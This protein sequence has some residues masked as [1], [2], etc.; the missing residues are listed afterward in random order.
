MIMDKR[1]HAMLHPDDFDVLFRRQGWLS[2]GYA[3]PEEPDPQLLSQR[4]VDSPTKSYSPFALFDRFGQNT[5]RKIL[6]YIY[7]HA[8]CT[9]DNL[10]L[11]CSNELLLAEHLDFMND[12]ELVECETDLWRKSRRCQHIDNIGRTLEWYVA[13]W[14]RMVLHAPAR[15]G[16]HV[17]NLADGGDL[18]VVAFVDGLRISVECKSG[19]DIPERQLGLFAQRA[20]EFSPDIAVLLIDTEADIEKH[21][22]V[23]NSTCQA[24]NPFRQQDRAGSL[25][26]GLR[27]GY[28]VNTKES[29]GDSIAAV[30][31]L[32]HSRVKHVPFVGS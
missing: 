4:W 9:R 25:Y 29:I 18:D 2:F 8:P 22:R 16:V 24:G 15:Y 17:D 10:A 12:Q 7:T 21:I 32:Y 1:V 14:F 30:L 6:G 13:E 31:R 11:I 28:V 26:W 23:L 20:S 3:R 19:R 27:T 5:F